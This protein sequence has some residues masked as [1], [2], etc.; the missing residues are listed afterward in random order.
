MAADLRDDEAQEA[1]DYRYRLIVI[2]HLL[3]KRAVFVQF[4]DIASEI[5][6]FRRDILFNYLLEYARKHFEGTQ[7]MPTFD[8][9]EAALH[10]G[11]SAGQ[12]AAVDVEDGMLLL[13]K[14]FAVAARFEDDAL[15]GRLL[16]LARQQYLENSVR[17]RQDDGEDLVDVITDVKRELDR[18]PFSR[19]M[20]SPLF[21]MPDK[22]LEHTERFPTGVNFL[23]NALDGG[24]QIGDFVGFLAPSGGGKTTMAIQIC[25]AQVSRKRHVVYFQTEQGVEGD[26]ALRT[27]VQA[28]MVERK[29]WKD[30]W[31]RAPAFA[32]ASFQRVAEDWKTYYHVFPLR[33]AMPKS[34]A[35]LFSYVEDLRDG[36]KAPLY[37]VIDWWGDIRDALIE[38]VANTQSE[39]VVRRVSRVWLKEI[40]TRAAQLNCIPFLLHQLSGEAAAKPAGKRQSSH[41]AQEDRNFNN[42]MDFCFTSSV[43]DSNNHAKVCSDKA[44]RFAKMECLVHLNGDLCMFQEVGNSDKAASVLTEACSEPD[45][46]DGVVGDFDPSAY[47]VKKVEFD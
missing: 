35:E 42:R 39:A 19:A 27:F 18:D 16:Q 22:F 3:R 45:L 32:R 43:L 26:I 9:L 38:N 17:S 30:G 23:D 44:R 20:E 46:T 41:A 10:A 24:G 2:K 7:S 1:V 25:A 40:K 47:T 34:I 31:Y 4:A 6:Y 29:H 8:A 36:G 15:V 14:W 12:L 37:I 5:G 13:R 11:A 28:T 21:Q 33:D